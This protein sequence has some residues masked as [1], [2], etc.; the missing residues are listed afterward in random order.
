MDAVRLRELLERLKSGETDVESVL[1]QVK[2]L[3]FADLGYARVDYHRALR[4]GVPEVIFGQGKT[5]EQIVGIA[6]ALIEAKQNVMVTR[7]GEEAAQHVLSQIPD[8]KYSRL[9]RV[10]TL[11]LQPIT[12]LPG[13][14]V[15]LVSAGTS[16]LPVAEE[17]AETLRMLGIPLQ[18]V[19]DVGVAGLHRMLAHLD[20]LSSA[21]AVIVVAGMEGALPS[22]VGGLVG[23]P[24]VAVPTSIGYGAA[25]NGFTALLGMLT[26]CASGVTVVN[27]DNGFGAAMAVARMVKAKTPAGAQ[28]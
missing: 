3:P 2:R 16:D 22:V 28:P 14:P 17:A 18:R 4:V 1:D 15:A 21:P 25:L 24:I 19:Y 10:A 27:I 8:M 6:R 20:V 5:P 9:A 26:G 11:E 13:T 12:A 7:I 23:S